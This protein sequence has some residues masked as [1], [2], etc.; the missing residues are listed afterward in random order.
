M[1]I[2]TPYGPWSPSVPDTK[3][4]ERSRLVRDHPFEPYLWE[5]SRCRYVN[6]DDEMCGAARFEH[7]TEEEEA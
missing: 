6:G 5:K 1:E 3:E 7:S 2:T 4:D